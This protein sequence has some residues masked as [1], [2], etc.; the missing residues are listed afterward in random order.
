MRLLIAAGGTGGHV[1]PGL[2]IAE[3][4]RAQE[5][6]SPV[7]FVGT[8]AGLEA[9]LVPAH[10]YPL[11][12]I[13]ISGMRRVG[14]GASLR[15][16]LRLPLALLQSARIVRRF[17]P[18][19]V[20]GVG[21]YASGPVVLAAALLGHPTLLAE[22]NSIPGLANRV[23]GRFARVVCVAFESAGARF[24]R[25]KVRLTGNPVRRGVRA[26][27][28]PDGGRPVDARSRV[29]VLGGSQGARGL[30]G[31]VADALALLAGRSLPLRVVH[32][33]GAADLEATRARYVAA[34]VDAETTAFIDDV[35][36]A[37]R[38]ADLVVAR[39]GATTIAEL[40]VAGRPAVLVPYP[41]AVDDHQWHNARPLVEAGAALCFRESEIGAARLAD[42][43]AR[44]LGDRARLFAMG[45][46]MAALGRPDAAARIV[47]ECRRVARCV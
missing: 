4:L 18:D 32:Q 19:V 31:V 36:A 43:I 41:Y 11:E 37:Y 23:L 1:F 24:A 40:T 21:G 25:G 47:D 45:R 15:S 5:P 14:P 33:A 16:L 34:G 3:E 8:R 39:A 20:V 6:Q 13:A 28:D 10:G 38:A 7:L 26:S 17:R 2:A 46:A 29:L 22:P 12:L 35:A 27:A 30:N 9:R 42:E 44:L